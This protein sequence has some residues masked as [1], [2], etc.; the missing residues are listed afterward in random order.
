MQ[1][2]LAID[3]LRPVIFTSLFG[4]VCA[5]LVFGRS[6]ETFRPFLHYHNAEFCEHLFRKSS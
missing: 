3:I 2:I 5:K 4:V 6:P 1:L